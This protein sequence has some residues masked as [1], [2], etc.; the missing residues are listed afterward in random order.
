MKRQKHLNNW[1]AKRILANATGNTSGMNRKTR[2]LRTLHE[3]NKQSDVM[4]KKLAPIIRIKVEQKRRMPHAEVV[5]LGWKPHLIATI[6]CTP[7]Q[8]D[9][10]EGLID[11]LRTPEAKRTGY[12]RKLLEE[13]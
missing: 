13:L 9:R 3:L 5:P 1:R 2:I 6:R 10:I 11:S 4:D 12:M 8:A 7:E